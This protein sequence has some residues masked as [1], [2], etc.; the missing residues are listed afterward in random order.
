MELSSFHHSR[1]DPQGVPFPKGQRRS[2]CEQHTEIPVRQ[3]QPAPA[4]TQI[5]EHKQEKPL[6]EA[7]DFSLGKALGKV[8]L[9]CHGE[10]RCMGAGMVT[11]RCP[12]GPIQP[13]D[14]SA[15]ATAGPG[16]AGMR[17][18]GSPMTAFLLF[19]QSCGNFAG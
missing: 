3:L 17:T 13:S 11:C 12:G 9:R 14:S 15:Q 7:R 6:G 4:H 2:G 10:P 5:H 1:T 19:L 18:A 8:P 16:E